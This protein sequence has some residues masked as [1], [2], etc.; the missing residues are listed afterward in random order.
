[1]NK[2]KEPTFHD[3]YPKADIKVELN[4]KEPTSTC[5][6]FTTTDTKILE[7]WSKNQIFDRN[8]RT[9]RATLGPSGGKRAYQG[10]TGTI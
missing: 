5:Y 4:R 3:I 10:L 2:N 8:I 6:A 9:F 1:M 7:P